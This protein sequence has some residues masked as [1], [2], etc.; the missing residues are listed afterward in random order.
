[1]GGAGPLGDVRTDVRSLARSLGRTENSPLCPIGHRPLRVRC[2]KRQKEEEEEEERKK[3]EGTK[4]TVE[5]FL[6][7]KAAFD[8]ELKKKKG[9]KAK[10]EKNEKPTGRGLFTMD[11]TLNDSDIKFLAS[12]GDTAVTVDESLFEDLD[13]L[14]LDDD[15][16]DDPDWCPGDSD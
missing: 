12:T 9:L 1:M 8:E 7:W 3:L 5:S 2:P 14:D 13:D 4:V 11:S 16:E 6:A 15:D 10:A